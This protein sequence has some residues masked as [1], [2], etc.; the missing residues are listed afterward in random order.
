MLVQ[1]HQIPRLL[2]DQSRGIGGCWW[3]PLVCQGTC[4]GALV[5]LELQRCHLWVLT[6][7]YVSVGGLGHVY[8]LLLQTFQSSGRSCKCW[9]VGHLCWHPLQWVFGYLALSKK[10]G[11]VGGCSKIVCV[12]G[13]S[14]FVALEC[15]PVLL[16]NWKMSIIA[17][18][19]SISCYN[20]KGVIV[21]AVGCG[22]TEPA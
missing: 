17:R 4:G 19:W 13:C 16:G 14:F 3:W 6:L 11:V 10:L 5:I 12:G 22:P 2:V 20:A 18:A 7:Y 15:L 1:C 9:A 21:L 8:M